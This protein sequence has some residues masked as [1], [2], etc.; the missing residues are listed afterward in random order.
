[1]T[2][3]EMAD[4]VELW[5]GL[6]DSSI[7]SEEELINTQL[8]L[9]VIDLLARTKCVVRCVM[10]ETKA[11]VDEYILP[12]HLLALVEVEDGKR[13][14][15]RRNQTTMSPAFTLIRSDILRIAPVPDVDG[16]LQ[17]WAVKR[18]D[19]MSPG[20]DDDTPPVSPG[21]DPYGE[22]PDEFQDAIVT[23]ALW[24]CA[25]YTDDSGSG[26]G[27]RY[28]IAYEGQDGRQ[29]RLMQIRSQVN[30]RGTARAPGRHVR[31]LRSSSARGA[32]VG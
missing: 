4:Q 17:V 2:R 28:R 10:L 25:D 11:G 7:T 29:G 3:K 22:I 9:G 30:R 12:H 13:P 27:E 20:G 19:P 31:G 1:M 18:P 5:L 21:N 15:A 14:K 6:Q 26:Q 16:T 8:N 23:Y 32:W 24:H